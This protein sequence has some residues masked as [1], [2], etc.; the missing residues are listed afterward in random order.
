MQTNIN[1]IP[2]ELKKAR[3]WGLYRLEWQEKKKK[4]NKIPVDPWTGGPG[5]STNQDT[6]SD[7]NTAVAAAEKMG[8]DKGGLAFYF[9]NGFAGVDLDHIGDDIDTYING[10][11]TDPDTNEVAHALELTDHSYSEISTSREGI[12]IIVKGK[13][14][15]DRRRR[16]HFEMYDSGRFFALTGWTIGGGREVK[17]VD[18]TPAYTHYIGKDKVFPMPK[19][20]EHYEN[21]LTTDEIIEKASNSTTGARFKILMYGGWEQFYPSQS[22][23]DMAF[24]NDLAFWTGKD[25]QKM[26]EIFR[27]S[28]LYRD[29]Y[30]EKHGKTSYGAGLLY[31][32]INET[33]NVYN[34]KRDDRQPLKY[35]IGDFLNKNK[36]KP[37]RTWD[38]MGNAQRFLDAYGDVFRYSYIDK[39]WYWYNGTYWEVD[40]SGRILEAADKVVDAM[41][42]EKVHVS[43]EADPEEAL[44]K[45]AKFKSKSRSNRSKKNMVEEVQHHI[46]VGHD[47]WDRD[48]M[49]LNTP[50]GYVDLSSGILYPSDRE[51]MFSKITG[52]E[53]S[54]TTGCEQWL[55][56]LDTTFQGDKALIHEVQKMVGYSA[57]AS[58]V[59]QV[60]FILLGNG[61]NGKSVFMNTIAK[62]LG[63]YA[64]TMQVSS[65]MTKRSQSGPTSDIARLENARLVISSEAN[66]GD[67]LDESLLKQ[68]TGGDKMVAR[69]MYGADFEFVPKFKL[70]MATNHL[71]F[72]R[73][74]D[75][76]I[77][78]RLIGVPFTH[79]V[80]LEEVDKNLEAK[81]DR[82]QPGILSWIVDGAIAWQ[83]EGLTPT[84]SMREMIKTY[85]K[86]MDIIERFVADCCEV[87]EGATVKAS[88]IYQAYK[89]WALENSEH[90]Y[91]NTKFGK[92]LSKKFD[93]KKVKGTNFYKKIRLKPIEDP[94]T[95]FLGN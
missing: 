83:S 14:P 41:D 75:D 50:A 65:I 66:E 81:L 47:E 72:I 20:Y 78:R 7:F 85:R 60:M 1:G 79:Q 31:K 42:D 27:Q 71:P 3:Q 12:H 92:E 38:D 32:A 86:E 13:I 69:F 29:K 70:W 10:S 51:K 55:K 49:L 23:A 73:G 26:D 18:L 62:A 22:E 90:V 94:R 19:R 36:P 56:F 87:E 8:L 64:M 46:A 54:D 91:T 30:D 25:F 21:N 4:F 53:F 40:K 34:P 88:A 11:N 16:G 9:A 58:T 37:P 77:W 80:P 48:G 24:A 33:Q 59:E 68:M 43:E 35:E 95:N 93:K 63:N 45:W 67:R 17:E 39:S 57:T 6:W 5:S 28:S 15:G 76:G 2:E 61:R 84:A 89:K 82:E 44:K 74:T 52:T